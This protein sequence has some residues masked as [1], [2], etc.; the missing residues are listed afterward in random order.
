MLKA[1]FLATVQNLFSDR[2]YC[3]AEHN[4][5]LFH[6]MCRQ[7]QNFVL[8]SLLLASEYPVDSRNQERP[9]TFPT[10]TQSSYIWVVLETIL[11]HTGRSQATI[12]CVE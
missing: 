9:W 11:C 10:G 8:M 5:R 4:G 7:M 2:L 1:K 12:G 3:R 6:T